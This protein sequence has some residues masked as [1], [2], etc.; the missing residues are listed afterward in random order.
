MGEEVSDTGGQEQE[1]QQRLAAEAQRKKERKKREDAEK[2]QRKEERKAEERRLEEVAAAAA[3]EVAAAA[4]AAQALVDAKAAAVAKVES[5]RLA[6]IAAKKAKKKKSDAGLDD[7]AVLELAVA[8]NSAAGGTKA[9]AAPA[10]ASKSASEAE[11]A[12]ELRGELKARIQ[13]TQKSRKKNVTEKQEPSAEDVV[14][15][16]QLATAAEVNKRRNRAREQ[17][18][19][20]ELQAKGGK[21]KS[22]PI[23]TSPAAVEADAKRA[24][25]SDTEATLRQL[26]LELSALH[27]EVPDTI[28]SDRLRVEL[29]ERVTELMIKFDDLAKKGS[30][31]FLARRRDG[32]SHLHALA[33]RVGDGTG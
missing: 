11:R 30:E 13:L 8:A 31:E 28:E 20:R 21:E 6:V 4:A 32:I 18:R 23:T 14:K 15:A 3:A 17:E 29:S 2:R 27:K 26:E 9:V 7:L 19:V 22:Q 1:E 24:L 12:A 10:A 33:A 5:D 16:Q 25:P